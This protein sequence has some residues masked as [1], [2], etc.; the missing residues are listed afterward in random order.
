[1]DVV[2][3]ATLCCG[4]RVIWGLGLQQHAEAFQVP[5]GAYEEGARDGDTSCNTSVECSAFASI[6][7]VDAKVREHRISTP[8]QGGCC[9]FCVGNHEIGRA[10]CRA[11]VEIE[12]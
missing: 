9:R 5:D 2:V 3:A 1:M 7:G 11:R 6:V 8:Y 4:S 10:S 12:V